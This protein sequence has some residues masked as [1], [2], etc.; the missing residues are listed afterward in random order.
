MAEPVAAAP[1]WKRILAPIL[2]WIMLFSVGGSLIGAVTGGL[3]PGGFDLKGWPAVLL[4]VIVIAYFYVGRRV[5]GGTLW[6]RF[7]GIGR[8]QPK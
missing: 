2:D 4:L 3:E 5:A 1:M 7:F 8:P 6:D